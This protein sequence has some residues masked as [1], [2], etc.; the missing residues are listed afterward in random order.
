MV[1]ARTLGDELFLLGD[2]YSLVRDGIFEDSIFIA[3]Q[4]WTSTIS[5]IKS[6]ASVFL[7][8]A[9]ASLGL[10]TKFSEL[11]NLGFKPMIVGLTAAITVGVVS[12][13]T[14]EIFQKV[15]FLYLLN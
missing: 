9:M 2:G 13:I 3:D 15:Y 14:L 11:K 6:S 1:T 12:I 10:A 4:A 8:M 5:F 7:S